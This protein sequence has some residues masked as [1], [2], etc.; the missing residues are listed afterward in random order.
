M[1]ELNSKGHQSKYETNK[2]DG[3]IVND[4]NFVS[5]LNFTNKNLLNNY[6]V[7]FNRLDNYCSK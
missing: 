6:S 1:L 2:F 5:N 4:I 7:N 3:L